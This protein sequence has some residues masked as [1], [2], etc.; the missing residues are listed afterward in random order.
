VW[1]ASRVSASK[2]HSEHCRFN[3]SVK[4]GFRFLVLFTGHFPLFKLAL[5]CATAL[6][7]SLNTCLQRQHWFV[8][9]Q[10]YANDR[11]PCTCRRC[12]RNCRLSPHAMSQ[13]PHFHCVCRFCGTP[14]PT[15]FSCSLCS[16]ICC[17]GGMQ[18]LCCLALRMQASREQNHSACVVIALSHSPF[19]FSASEAASSHTLQK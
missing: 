2:S 14:S 6:L 12:N 3:A 1:K 18:V 19:M 17:G 4:T 16:L 9:T 11:I 10:Q 13:R 8:M 15:S 5:R 7:R